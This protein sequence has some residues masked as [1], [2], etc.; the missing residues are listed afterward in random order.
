MIWVP[1]TNEIRIF[2]KLNRW[3]EFDINVR[4]F[5]SIPYIFY[6]YSFHPN[7]E[8]KHIIRCCLTFLKIEKKLIFVEFWNMRESNGL[9]KLIFALKSTQFPHIFRDNAV[10]IRQTPL[11]SNRFDF[12]HVFLKFSISLKFQVYNAFIF[13]KCGNFSKTLQ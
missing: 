10:K 7:R 1:S 9:Q 2:I 5:Q 4:M 11:G 12:L 13:E 3:I 8:H 6:N